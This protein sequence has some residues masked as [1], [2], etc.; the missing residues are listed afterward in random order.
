MDDD[1]PSPPSSTTHWL[2]KRPQPDWVERIDGDKPWE[3]VAPRP[4][5]HG[6]TSP[7]DVAAI[8]R[9]LRGARRILVGGTCDRRPLPNRQRTASRLAMKSASARAISYGPVMTPPRPIN[10]T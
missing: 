1:L 5:T 8:T 2:T 9:G 4:H 3:R 7:P 6:P 10:S